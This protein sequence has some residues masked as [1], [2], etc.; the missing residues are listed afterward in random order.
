MEEGE[1]MNLVIPPLDTAMMDSA[2][3][4]QDRLLK[5]RGALGLLE[6]L[7]IQLAGMT[8]RLDWLP[9]RRA[10]IVF[11]ADHGVTVH[12]ISTVPQA[13]TAYM[14]RQFLAGNAAINVLSRQMGARL[15]V[16]DVGVNGITPPMTTD[17]ARFVS[18]SIAPG[19]AD[20][21]QSPAMSAAQA[22]DALTIGADAAAQAI[23][24]GC[25]VL[26][27]GEMGI[28]NTTSASAIVAALTGAPVERVTG[29]GTG[30]DDAALRRKT[31]VITAGL[32]LHTPADQ[33]TLA[34]IGGFEIG[35]MAGA[36][37]FAASRRVPVV[38]DGLICTASAL[39]ARQVIPRVTDYLIAGHVGAEPGH[40]VALDALGLQPLLTLEMRL[41]E[42]TGAVL[43]LPLI[44]AAV[45]TLNEMGTLDVG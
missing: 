4:H 45:R 37:L 29:R 18:R 40:A 43:A 10:V 39:I 17:A 6:A 26:I 14:V 8:G 31:A 38:L 28:G 35:A 32:T 5:P 11:A 3:S 30:I 27:L 16:V 7:S 15:T 20:F 9:T 12:G 19:T 33:D 42:G 2:R 25:D 22:H 23:A 24:D 34:K 44:E 1:P 21:T 41:G 13:V 36:M